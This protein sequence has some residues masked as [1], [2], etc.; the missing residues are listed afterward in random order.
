M[1]TDRSQLLN[2]VTYRIAAPTDE[3]VLGEMLYLAVFV[4]PG[5]TPPIPSILTQPELARYVNGWGRRGDDGVIALTRDAYAIGAAWVRLWSED[6]RGYGFV[7]VRTPEL[8]IAVR[9]ECRGCG[10]GTRLLRQLLHRADQAYEHVS[11]SVSV[12]NPAVRLYDKF[13][14]VTVSTDGASIMMKRMRK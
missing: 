11:L 4:P 9:P 12:A 6:D 14:F 1:D 8:S 2:T 10:I 3:P 5:A 13:G 7:D